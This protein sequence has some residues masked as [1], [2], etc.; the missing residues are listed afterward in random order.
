[1]AKEIILYNLS[2]DVKA[3]SYLQTSLSW[4]GVMICVW[5]W[6]QA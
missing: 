3:S 6:I 4:L 5:F 2:D 1:M